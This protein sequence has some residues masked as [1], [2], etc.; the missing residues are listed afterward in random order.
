MNLSQI[1]CK[2]LLVVGSLAA[3]AHHGVDSLLPVAERTP[4]LRPPIC[5]YGRDYGSGMVTIGLPPRAH[6]G[7]VLAHERLVDEIPSLLWPEN[8]DSEPYS[9]HISVIYGVDEDNRQAI[10][11]SLAEHVQ[12]YEELF[13]ELDDLV[14]WDLGNTGKTALVATVRDREG[15]LASLHQALQPLT[16]RSERYPYQPHITIAYLI[17]G[18]RP[19]AATLHRLR[20]C[21][22]PLNT[23]LRVAWLTDRCGLVDGYEAFGGNTRGRSAS[24][25]N[26][27]LPI[28]DR[29]LP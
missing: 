21:L 15:H 29:P 23:T 16:G 25:K 2:T 8:R 1:I 17:Q 5:R 19:P 13:L 22:T 26:M 18:A 6:C 10:A 7:Y 12:R 20:V 11:M 24:D 28:H 4:T 14:F 9:P 27:L 3:C